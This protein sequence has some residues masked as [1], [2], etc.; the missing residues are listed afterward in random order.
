[1]VLD[2][3]L[4][5]VALAHGYEALHAAAVATPNRGAIA[6]AAPSGGGKST[7]L[8]GLLGEGLALIAD[9]VLV[10]EPSPNGG[11]PL[12]HPAPPLM[13]VPSV[14]LPSLARAV[15][16]P[17]PI[18]SLGQER[19]IAVP[20]HRGPLPLH[21]FVQLDRRP[22]AQLSLAKI[23]HPLVPLMSS[24]MSFPRTSERERKRFEL[25]SVIATTSSMWRL[26]ADLRTPAE[27]LAEALLH[28]LELKPLAGTHIPATSSR[29]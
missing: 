28:G 7:L 2:S 5:T 21:A 13:S 14:R 9:D 22:G 25:A 4:F 3:A 10:L 15:S 16:S 12:A 1:V 20:V 23:E 6:I 27:V 17:E 26:S 18:C 24:L 29:C 19:W 11:P 8:S